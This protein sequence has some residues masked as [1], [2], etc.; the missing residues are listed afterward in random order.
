MKTE[1]NNK[2]LDINDISFTVK[3]DSDVI[4]KVRTGEI[5]H[6]LM[7]IDEDNQNLILENIDIIMLKLKDQ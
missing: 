2:E 4:K 1:D 3:V 6:I 7:D 5:T